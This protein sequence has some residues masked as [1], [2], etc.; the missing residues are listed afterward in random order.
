MIASLKTYCVRYVVWEGLGGVYPEWF[1]S[2]VMDDLLEDEF[3]RV[4][5]VQDGCD[6]ILL[7]ET[8]SIFIYNEYC[9]VKILD[10]MDF[11]DYYVILDNH[12][13]VLQ[14]NCVHAFTWE[15]GGPFPEWF[16]PYVRLNIEDYGSR[17]IYAFD[18]NEM[19]DRCVFIWNGFDVKCIEEFDFK[20]YYRGSY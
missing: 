18:G 11:A 12:Y 15:E 13:A 5:W 14:E 2:R 20:Q 3:R 8:V 16:D 17:V 9:E 4:Y 19:S 7:Y 6:D 10:A 1:I